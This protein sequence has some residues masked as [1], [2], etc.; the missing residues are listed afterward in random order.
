MKLKK[1]KTKIQTLPIMKKKTKYIYNK[2]IN[3]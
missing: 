1:G 3:K 2:K